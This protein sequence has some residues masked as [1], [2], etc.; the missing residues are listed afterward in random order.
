VTRPAAD[1]C[2]GALRLHE[3]RDG[4]L[5]RV[6]LPGGRVDRT[7]LRALADA[8]DQLGNG[9]V[10][11]TVRANVQ[12]RG[13]APGAGEELA[14]RIAAAG[15]LPSFPHERV[16]NI[17][18]S[19]LAG[20]DPAASIDA[21]PLVDAL[22]R[23]ICADPGL[24]RLSGRFA[25]AVEDGSGAVMGLDRD[26]ALAPAGDAIALHVGDLDTGL[27]AGPD[28]AAAMAAA[29]AR[30]FLA[31]LGD[32]AA[33]RVADLP[34]GAARVAERLRGSRAEG[35]AEVAAPPARSVAPPP[36]PGPAGPVPQ[37]DGRVA[38]AAVPPLGRMRAQALRLLADLRRE[39]R[40]SVWRTVVVP[41]IPPGAVREAAAALHTL[42]LDASPGS[43]WLGLSACAG[44]A[45]CAEA[46]ADVRADAAARAGRRGAGA[47]PE[48]W[49]GC[50]RRCGTPAGPV[51]VITASPAGYVMTREEP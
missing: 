22:D 34:Q 50:G 9:F 18:A 45:G 48:H 51:R 17:F 33:W 42:G 44:A 15:L 36:P 35:V 19:P 37:P 46:L 23:A 12:L 7:G 32:A 47:P 49:A 24:T 5:A 10:D 43:A 11:L 8:A 26:V 31:E 6:R 30:A 14:T 27:R 4:F 20:R 38:L 25:F 39:A 2:P 3:A 16:R 41:D 40:V 28:D 29:A 13:L 1:R 21:R